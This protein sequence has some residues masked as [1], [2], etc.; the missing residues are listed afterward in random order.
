MTKIKN[1]RCDDGRWFWRLVTDG[2]EDPGTYFTN[3]MG[4]GIFYQ[5]D[6]TCNVRQLTGT[7]QFSACETASGTRRKLMRYYNEEA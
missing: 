5:D 6:K 3:R 1:L 7:C 4:E 2:R